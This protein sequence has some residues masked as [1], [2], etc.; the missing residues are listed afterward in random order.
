M[1]KLLKSA[2]VLVLSL[3]VLLTAGLV[4]FF[5]MFPPEKIKELAVSQLEPVLGRNIQVDH[6][7]VSIFPVLG[8]ALSGFEVSNTQRPGFASDEPFVKLD[9]F[10]I[11]ISVASVFKG[12]PEISA[13]ILDK[14]IL[15]V[16][17]DTAGAFN[18]DDLALLKRSKAKAEKTEDGVLALPVPLTLRKFII[19]NGEINYRDQ[20]EN[21]TVAIGELNQEIRLSV[22]KQLKNVETSG[23]L[24]LADIS[25]KTKEITKPL[26][27][28]TFTLSHDII[29]DLTAG[30]AQVK[31][32]RL[33]LQKIFLNLTGTVS[34][35]NGP[36]P[37]IDLAAES[38]PFDL[39]HI[40]R[41]V[42]VELV[43]D[44]AKLT[45]SGTAKLDV[46]VKGALEKE[47]PLPV[48]G[49]LLLK[50]GM[51]K[52]TEL[53]KSV[54][55]INGHIDFT[56]NSFDVRKLS[57]MFGD[58]P[59]SIVASVVDF[60]EPLVDATVDADINLADV[61]DFAQLPPKTSV[62]GDLKAHIRARGKADAADPSKLDMS[63]TVSLKN[64]TAL[65]PSLAKP[66]SVN[67]TVNLTSASLKNEL[68]VQIGQSSLK[69]NAEARNYLS[70]ILK[71]EKKNLP[72]PRLQFQL[73]S[74]LLNVDEFMPAEEKKRG[75]GEGKK[76]APMIAPLPGVDMEGTVSAKKVIYNKIRMNDLKVDVSVKND[77]ADVKVNTGVSG[78]WIKN[79]LNADLRNVENVSFRNRLVVS[80]V[81][82][83][84]LMTT[85]GSYIEP[86]TAL[87]RELKNLPS[88]LFG[89]VNINGA[90]SGNGA[91]PE[92][93]TRTLSGNLDLRMG[94]G[95]IA[96]SL[97]TKRLAGAV[98][99]F[100]K[101][102]DIHF[103]DLSA[104]VRFSDG[105]AIFDDL[106]FFS[107]AAGDWAGKGSVGFDSRLDMAVSNRLPKAASGPLLSLQQKGKNTLHSLLGGTQFS[108]G[109]S[110]LNDMGIPSDKD[111]RVTV[112]LALKGSL[113]DPGVVFTGFGEGDGSLKKEHSVQDKA[114]GK[115]KEKMEQQKARMEKRLAE[116][117]AKAEEAL[118]E[119]SRKQKERLEAEKK[120]QE[121]KLRK[122]A[123]QLKSKGEDVK[124]KAVDK[125]KKLW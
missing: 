77:I 65:T 25:L 114:A 35:L 46:A 71:D 28:L 107:N 31:S 125:L 50:N 58:N 76:T 52:Y 72:R 4:T 118:R 88:N 106:K 20:K 39:K 93:F 116:Q 45:G 73:S 51:V 21:R 103:R 95:R 43:P 82:I 29:A 63:G 102:D 83:N 89:K 56:D 64:V 8:V 36:A 113:S 117:R 13:V 37:N 7:K 1:N 97:M 80:N 66:A 101:L 119:R 38:D 68:A 10:L 26:S 40:L 87:N 34:D 105:E 75:R 30:T 99:K 49:S 70:F 12:Y 11:Q 67:G 18:F 86:T 78:G 104:E 84:E 96:N 122:K 6:A 32:I 3:A 48:K 109:A 14:P 57:L 120:A 27:D 94:E 22:D 59:V 24:E 100:I 55:S 16:E 5:T 81:E 42:P 53:P 23:A 124:N 15:L 92:D 108:G 44:I 91:A 60:K 110:F 79:D 33:S 115:L 90:F 121:E 54:N 123:E 69:L 47:K 111:G 61:K 41:E 98:E 19:K 85:M 17:A 9:N 74:A 62:S 112:K 2:L